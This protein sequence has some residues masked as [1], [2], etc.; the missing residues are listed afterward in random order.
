MLDL[1]RMLASLRLQGL[2]SHVA[3]RKVHLQMRCFVSLQTLCLLQNGLT[4]KNSVRS[5]YSH[6]KGQVNQDAAGSDAVRK[7]P[8][9]EKQQRLK[10]QKARLGGAS[11]EGETES[12]YAFD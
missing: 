5:F 1:Q 11:T 8:A 3:H 9:A 7:I 4:Q 10:D 12:S 6:V 2:L